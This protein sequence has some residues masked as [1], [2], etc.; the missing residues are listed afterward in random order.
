MTCET[1]PLSSKTAY[2][3]DRIN[4]E[5]DLLIP[6]QTTPYQDIFKASRY[7]LLAPGKR[8]RGSL[9]LACTEML[10]GS[11]KEAIW[12]ACSIEMVHAYSLI[13]DDL[14]CMDDDDLRRGK[15]TLHK[16]YS[17]WLALLSGD[18]L[19]T[20][21]F[22]VLSQSPYLSDRSKIALV[23]VLSSRS[24]AHGMIGGQVMDLIQEHSSI[25]FTQVELTHRLKTGALIEASCEF[26]G[27]I[28]GLSIEEA[29]PLKSYGQKI[30]LAFQII[31]DILDVQGS[32]KSLGKMPGSDIQRDKNTYVSHL[33]IDASK[34]IAN[35]LI[36]KAIDDIRS[37][38]SNSDI[39]AEIAKY[40]VER[41]G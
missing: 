21:S 15:P 7:S 33:G 18:Y 35:R 14:P 2:F 22:E 38:N 30:G 26:G 29:E 36:E 4:T 25:P 24:G 12:P 37:F 16:A 11:L 17:E 23:N 6:N 8:L 34:Q 10:G 28:C 1:S 3:K 19:L 5:L 9:V 31:D 20:K 41:I 27:I 39:L 40:F 32:P 13:H